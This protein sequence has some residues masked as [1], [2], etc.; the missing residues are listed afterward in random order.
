MISKIMSSFPKGN[1]ML[2]KCKATFSV[3]QESSFSSV[4][5]PVSINSKLTTTD[6]LFSKVKN[7]MKSIKGF[8]TEKVGSKSIDEKTFKENE[9]FIRETSMYDP[10][11]P[12]YIHANYSVGKKSK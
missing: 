12:D 11:S 5:K 6:K 10:N 3:R 7:I 1:T 8:F 4:K 2:N 9:K